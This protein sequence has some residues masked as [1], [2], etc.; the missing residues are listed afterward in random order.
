M[1]PSPLIV[2]RTTW[3][4]NPGGST[5]SFIRHFQWQLAYSTGT[6]SRELPKHPPPPAPPPP[7]DLGC[8][9]VQGGIS[10]LRQD[11]SNPSL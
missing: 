5:V 7:H 4:V 3:S 1:Y 8:G 2:G 10:Q 11:C 9:S 6:A